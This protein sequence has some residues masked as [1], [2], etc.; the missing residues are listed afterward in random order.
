MITS[1][2]GLDDVLVKLP[3]DKFTYIMVVG[4]QKTGKSSFI[5]SLLFQNTEF[6]IPPDTKNIEMFNSTKDKSYADITYISNGSTEKQ[7]MTLKETQDTLSEYKSN[8]TILRL[9]NLPIIKHVEWYIN[10]DWLSKNVRI[11]DTPGFNVLDPDVSILFY[12]Y[13]KLSDVIIW[14]MNAEQLEDPETLKQISELDQRGKTLIGVITHLDKIPPDNSNEKLKEA[15]GYYGKYISK[16]LFYT[17]YPEEEQIPIN[18]TIDE[19]KNIIDANIRKLIRDRVIDDEI[20]P[21]FD[22]LS[23]LCKKFDFTNLLSKVEAKKNDLD[24]PL[25]VMIVGDGKRGKSTLINALLSKNVAKVARTPKT[26]RIDIFQPTNGIPYAELMYVTDQ[27]IDIKKE[28]WETAE[29]IVDDIEKEKNVASKNKEEWQS[30]LRQVKWYVNSNWPNPNVALIDTPGF[31]QLRVDTSLQLKTLYNSKGIQLEREDGFNEYYYRSNLVLW[32]IHAG[33][34]QERDALDKLEDVHNEGKTIVGVITHID[35]FPEESW[36][37]ILEGARNSFG[38][39]INR[40]VLC[41]AGAQDQDLKNKTVNELKKVVEEIISEKEDEIKINESKDFLNNTTDIID[42]QLTS[43]GEMFTQNCITYIRTYNKVE[44]DINNSFLNLTKSIEEIL[45]AR[46]EYCI[47]KLDSIYDA[48]EGEEHRFKKMI[49]QELD[50]NRTNEKV[51]DSIKRQNENLGSMVYGAY[52]SIEWQT[53]KIGKGNAQLRKSE[54]N[55]N[56]LSFNDTDKKA[57]FTIDLDDNWMDGGFKVGAA[58]AA[59]GL[60][61]LGPIGLLAGGIGYLYGKYKKRSEYISTARSTISEGL[62]QYK[63]YIIKHLEQNRSTIL[64]DSANVLNEY[65]I[66][67]N[68]FDIWQV[69][70][71][72]KEMDISLNRL[73][74]KRKDGQLLLFEENKQVYLGMSKFYHRLVRELQSENDNQKKLI[75]IFVNYHFSKL[76]EQYKVLND[77]LIEQVKNA[78]FSYTE[79]PLKNVQYRVLISENIYENPYLRSKGIDEDFIKVIEVN[80]IQF[81][82]LKLYKKTLMEMKGYDQI[83][84]ELFEKRDTKILN[85]ITTYINDLYKPLSLEIDKWRKLSERVIER[86][87]DDK[88]GMLNF[89][90]YMENSNNMDQ[91]VKYL[92]YANAN[93]LNREMFEWKW[94]DESSCKD[95][96][97][98]Y[99]RTVQQ[100][101]RNLISEYQENF[102]RY[103]DQRV[104]EHYMKEIKNRISFIKNQDPQKIIVRDNTYYKDI[105]YEIKKYF[106]DRMEFNMKYFRSST[107]FISLMKQYL[108][109]NLSIPSIIDVCINEKKYP[110]FASDLKDKIEEIYN[111]YIDKKTEDIISNISKECPDVTEWDFFIRIKFNREFSQIVLQQTKRGDKDE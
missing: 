5:N 54:F 25:Y 20:K 82:I 3:K 27:K 68:G 78:P 66:D 4:K 1:Q 87:D 43:I 53:V 19:I 34:L 21:R 67:I 60:I 86:F 33:K 57:L 101:K 92:Y 55:I 41:A 47:R 18:K 12:D 29:K 71:K 73:H 72:V 45:D 104:I 75:R 17:I 79:P 10:C 65:F 23:V 42:G 94:S 93:Y 37:E 52:K 99:F 15:Q 28:T 40:F 6:I 84:S 110:F 76:K 107:H 81:N 32:C 38:Q 59:A 74:N 62:Q 2:T 83:I 85:D 105:K 50:F 109:G 69:I 88:I 31:S 9:L 95:K 77:K 51:M 24:E 22:L 106:T 70:H 48:C 90:H 26:W 63:D 8:L 14:C 46:Q 39:Y 35:Q 11:I 97:I 16:F 98:E 89:Y 13:Y 64:L 111:N 102:K 36:N 100:E 30:D 49:E 56:E 7:R 58:S 103:W 91:V 96:I 61:F 44:T 108:N 80:N